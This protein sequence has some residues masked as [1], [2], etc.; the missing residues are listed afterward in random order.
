MSFCTASHN[1]YTDTLKWHC[2]STDRLYTSLE[3]AQWL[4]D[5]QIRS[6]G[7]IGYNRIGVPSILS[8]KKD[9]K[10][11]PLYSVTRHYLEEQ[12]QIALMSYLVPSGTSRKSVLMLSTTRPMHG[13]TKDDG[14]HKPALYKLYDYTKAS[15]YYL[16]LPITLHHSRTKI[17]ISIPPTYTYHMNLE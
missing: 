14:H 11:R 3:Q 17:L 4:L 2:I 15:K 13:V 8:N 16:S 7:T 9:L 5:H 1:T 10:K 6:I 12:N